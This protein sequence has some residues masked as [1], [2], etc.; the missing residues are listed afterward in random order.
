MEAKP[1]SC[2]NTIDGTDLGCFQYSN[3]RFPHKEAVNKFNT[4]PNFLSCC[5]CTDNCLNS[6][7]CACQRLSI[8]TWKRIDPKSEWKYYH[9]YKNKRLN[10]YVM[11]GIF[12]CNANCPC[13]KRCGNRVVQNGLRVQLQL[14][15][16][17]EKGWG[18]RVLHDVPKGT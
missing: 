17:L 16:T 2:V 13:D 12:E 4:D 3:V 15:K 1:I 7:T 9:C 6:K 5:D 14:F 10:D 8:E 18:V 11:T